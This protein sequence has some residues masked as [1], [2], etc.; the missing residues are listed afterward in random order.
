ME[1]TTL[2]PNTHTHVH[3]F[4]CISTGAKIVK[5]FPHGSVTKNLPCNAGDTGST[6]GW[7]YLTP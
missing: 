1:A 6:P 2:A 4:S 3:K 7:G 5:D